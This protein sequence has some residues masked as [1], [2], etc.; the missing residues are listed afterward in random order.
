[1][2]YI[3]SPPSPPNPPQPTSHNLTLPT[4][5]CSTHYDPFKALSQ[6]KI[7]RQP[8]AETGH[9]DVTCHKYNTTGTQGN[10]G[11][12]LP[13]IG[14]IS[15]VFDHEP[16]NVV[17]V[18]RFEPL[19]H[20]NHPRPQHSWIPAARRRRG[21]RASLL[22]LRTERR[23]PWCSRGVSER[24]GRRRHGGGGSRGAERAR[25]TCGR[26]GAESSRGG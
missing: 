11:P 1:M 19:I 9:A 4:T 5:L 26:C 22:L 8:T 21:K 20:F 10:D 2:K 7:K 16:I 15:H 6:K 14:K 18:V 25:C 3:N 24:G 17:D 23:S 12:A 13:Y